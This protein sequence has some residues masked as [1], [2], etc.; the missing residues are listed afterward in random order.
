MRPP[1]TTVDA[2][3][4]RYRCLFIDA[5]GVLISAD[6][7]LPGAAAFIDRLNADRHPYL[8]VTND[9]SR[10]PES[11]A[12]RYREMGLAL[13]GDRVVTSGSVLTP[14]FRER[15]LRGAR[16]MVLGPEDSG[17]YVTEAGGEVLP[18]G[19]TQDAE[20]LVICD[21]RGYDLRK[22]LDEAVTLLFRRVDAGRDIHLVLA[23]G[24]LLYPAGGNRYGFT[25][26]A[27]AL[28]LEEALALRYPHRPDLRFTVLG[29]PHAP[30]FAEAIRR[31]GTRD[32][33]MI[34]D[35]LETD[36][37]GAAAAGIDSALVTGGLTRVD[38]E[39]FPEGA[40]PTWI[41]T[42]VGG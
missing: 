8:I 36:I 15:G 30:I 10:S 42:G 29:K 27:A 14:Y 20:V 6:G 3:G 40:R 19:R 1:Q 17:G 7:A 9:A 16:C 31:A 25:A 38:H 32:V 39:D 22:G 35:Q 34:G 5:Y 13:S 24:D 37:R 18:P 23:N 12:A 4:S 41:L 26:R 2:L 33:V 28:L 21:E 11:S